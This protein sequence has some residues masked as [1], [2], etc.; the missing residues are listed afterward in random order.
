M[1]DKET[2]SGLGIGLLVGAIAGLA[3][4][5]LYA[6]RS[7]EKTRREIKEKADEIMGK[8]R[9]TVSQLKHAIALK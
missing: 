4:G 8:A 7:G 3:I 1:V 5:L 6:P 2:T 9:D